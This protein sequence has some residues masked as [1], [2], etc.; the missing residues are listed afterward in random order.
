MPESTRR[1]V[2]IDPSR[3]AHARLDS[4]PVSAVQL[5]GSF[6]GERRRILRQ[7]TLPSMHRLLEET[8]RIDNFR[9][10]AGK[11]PELPYQGAEYNDSDVYK[12]VEA[13]AWLLASDPDPHIANL[14]EGVIDEIAAAQ[15]PD[16][17]LDTYF[18]FERASERWTNFADHEMYCAGH[19]F[20]A[21]VA[22][23]RATGGHRLL[24][25]AIRLAE[26]LD[27]TFGPTDQGKR[28]YADGHEEVEM[29]LVELYRVTG[30]RRYLQLAEFF[31]DVRGRGLLKHPLVYFDS[32][33][34]QDHRPF[35]ELA[36]LDGHAVRALYYCCA[37]ADLYAERGDPGRRAALERLWQNMTT[38]R[39]YVTGGIGARYEG[40]AFGG[41]FELPNGRAH[42]ETCA[43]VAS[44][45]WNQRLLALDGEARYADLL[46]H[47]LYNAALP[48]IAL[49]G[50]AYFYQNPLAADGTH[51][52]R[53]WFHTACCPPNIARLLAA[54]PGYFYSTSA[55][56]VW[57]HLYG[58]NSAAIT[59]A[60]GR[61][62]VVEQQT[63]YPW[64]EDVTLHIAGAAEFSLYLRLPAW[65]ESGAQVWVNDALW[66]GERPPGSYLE[67]R[68]S[69]PSGDQV[70]LRLPMPVRQVR[71]HPYVYE[72]SGR[73]ALMRGPLIY[74]VEGVDY[75]GLDV[76]DL[77]L[78]GDADLR[79]Q[80]HPELLGGVVLLHGSAR[81]RRLDPAWQDQ[82][83]RSGGPGPPEQA[84]APVP[85][86][87]LPYYAWANRSPGGMQVWLRAQPL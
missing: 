57:V 56:G 7:V 39:I 51:R 70:R 24:D 67:L 13:A 65:C 20:Q 11:R 85:F 80:E 58:E 25:V 34:F 30:E 50:Q 29:A 16:G 75:P 81:L 23:Y 74:C 72:N 79:A 45:M 54:L 84:G 77:V 46:E 9:R 61:Q 31:V 63:R 32:V 38:R 64:H 27:R 33:Y 47:T 49:D 18:M 78:A 5:T 37:A 73:I 3:G 14:M 76:R 71:S 12:W 35:N 55:E 26:H 41:D 69:W 42:A 53:P 83:Y 17:Y 22:H 48:G 60:D 10:A 68:R 21:A 36:A 4:V 19:L 52:R 1:S 6:W 15:Q 44:V 62:V 8:G 66:P 28:V 86:V 43:A 40:E 87:A 82:L 2:V 59:L